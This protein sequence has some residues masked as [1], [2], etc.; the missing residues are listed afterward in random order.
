M[1]VI[2]LSN[3]MEEKIKK[4]LAEYGFSMDDLTKDELEELKQEIRLKEEGHAVLDGV[5]F[6]KPMYFKK[7]N[8]R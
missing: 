5:L 7:K 1:T 8:E 6:S 4:E 3:E 2:N